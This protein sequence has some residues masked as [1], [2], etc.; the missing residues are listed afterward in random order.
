MLLFIS[1]TGLLSIELEFICKNRYK[2]FLSALTITSLT[3]IPW[4]AHN[5][6]F[7]ANQP[8]HSSFNPVLQV[9]SSLF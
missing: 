8:F 1:V 5:F 9:K 4:S 6:F 2:L 7:F 3:V